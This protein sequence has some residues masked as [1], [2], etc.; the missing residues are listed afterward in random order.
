MA[1]LL[2]NVNRAGEFP[3]SS[4]FEARYPIWWQFVA[5]DAGSH[6]HLHR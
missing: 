5:T 2:A 3:S 1:P 6:S 4:D